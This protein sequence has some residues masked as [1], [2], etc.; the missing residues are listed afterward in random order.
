MT[1]APDPGTIVI[2]RH[3]SFV[4]SARPDVVLRDRMIE[5]GIPLQS[6]CAGQGNCGL[7]KIRV[8]EGQ[9][10]P[11]T[12][13]ERQHLTE[14]ALAQGWR[15]ACQFKLQGPATVALD[16]TQ[17]A[18]TWQTLTLGTLVIVQGKALPDRA[19]PALGL[20][21]D[22]GTTS[23]HASLW[24]MNSNYRLAACRGLNP[25]MNFGADVLTRLE[26]ARRDKAE[27]LAEILLRAIADGIHFLLASSNLGSGASKHIGHIGIVGNTAMLLLL[28]GTSPDQLLDVDGWNHRL[29][30]AEGDQPRWR[31]LWGVVP[32]TEITIHPPFAGF[33]GSDMLAA[34]QTVVH[35]ATAHTTTAM[36]DFGTNTEIVLWSGN[37]GWATSAPGGSALEGVGIQCG[38]LAL[39]GAVTRLENGAHPGRYRARMLGDGLPLGLSGSA[40]IDL[41]A[42]LLEEDVLRASGRFTDTTCH[43]HTFS[44]ELADQA[45]LGELSI[46]GRDIDAIQRAKASVAAAL[47]TLLGL[48][49]KHWRDIDRIYLCGLLGEHIHLGHAQSVGL[50]PDLP[51]SHFVRRGNAA[52]MGAELA[53]LA[54]PAITKTWDL[55]ARLHPFNLSQVEEYEDLYI[56]HLRLR[57][58]DTQTH[59]R[60]GHAGHRHSG[61]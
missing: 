7:C 59:P 24:D 2:T 43:A 4:L 52:L 35:E 13:P 28:T 61:L 14:G 1:P 38:M 33:M 31:T 48:A 20:V 46:R 16:D 45:P 29:H 50:L 27:V 8:I 22:I 11:V 60:C 53:L 5:S 51:A 30:L 23:L 21:I 34:M 56:H 32:D 36:I 39:D 26:A 25:Q 49:G 55:A 18:E 58:I 9:P 44:F 37:R 19:A 42:L 10:S 12:R 40:M 6:T 15:L 57:P 41:L 54:N 17:P 3:D 47:E